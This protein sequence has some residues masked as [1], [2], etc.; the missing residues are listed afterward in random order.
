MKRSNVKGRHGAAGLIILLRELAAAPKFADGRAASQANLE[1]LY[2]A[3]HAQRQR[4]MLALWRNTPWVVFRRLYLASTAKLLSGSAGVLP[5]SGSL[6]E[7]LDPLSE[8][9]DQTFCSAVQRIWGQPAHLR[10]EVSAFESLRER[11]IERTQLAPVEPHYSV[12]LDQIFCGVLLVRLELV[13][14]D[15]HTPVLPGARWQGGPSG[16]CDH[17]IDVETKNAML[18]IRGQQRF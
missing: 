11:I 15:R 9:Y 18:D 2:V 7:G 14:I 10:S 1:R 12:K 8:V 13:G 3:Q 6:R 5:A 4:G 17:D 16:C